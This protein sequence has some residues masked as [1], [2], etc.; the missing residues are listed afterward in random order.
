[1]QYTAIA[2]PLWLEDERRDIND[3]PELK[4]EFSRKG[5]GIQLCSLQKL[6]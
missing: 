6:A 5:G 4:A 3:A 1:M 2:L